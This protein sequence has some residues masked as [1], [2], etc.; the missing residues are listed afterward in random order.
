VKVSSA[1][2]TNCSACVYVVTVVL[3]HRGSA[4]GVRV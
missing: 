1:E 4:C 2:V 3:G